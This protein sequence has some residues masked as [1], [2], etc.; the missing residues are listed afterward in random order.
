MNMS[1]RGLSQD[2]KD[3]IEREWGSIPVVDATDKLRLFVSKEDIESSTRK[4]ASCCALANCCKRSL[5]SEGVFFYRTRAYV[6]IP[7]SNEVQRFF[8]S[9]SAKDFVA[10]FDKGEAVQAQEVVLVPASDCEKL[11]AKVKKQRW[12]KKKAKLLAATKAENPNALKGTRK[13]SKKTVRPVL[14]LVRSGT[15]QVKFTTG[16]ATGK[17]AK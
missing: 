14:H 4:D 11:D 12:Q 17:A 15:G 1:M 9:Q 5:G 8:L 3:V 13:V 6:H 2:E 16:S 10:S 7:T